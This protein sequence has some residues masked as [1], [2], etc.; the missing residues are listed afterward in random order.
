MKKAS[1]VRFWT[2]EEQEALKPYLESADKVPSKNDPVL[3]EFCKKFNRTYGATTVYI[4]TQRRKNK[5]GGATTNVV[6]KKKTPLRLYDY[7]EMAVLR[8]YYSSTQPVSPKDPTIKGFCKTF[9]RSFNS[10]KNHIMV[11]RRKAIPAP[12]AASG[13]TKGKVTTKDMAAVN[14]KKGEFVIPIKNWEIRTENGQANL[15]LMFSKPQ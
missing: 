9:K 1:T 13:T 12:V 10:V 4:Y 6:K 3:N 15:V 8:P 14:I 2:P 7:S 5:V 11:Q